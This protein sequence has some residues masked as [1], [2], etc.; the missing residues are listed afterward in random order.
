MFGKHEYILC[1]CNKSNPQ[2]IYASRL[3]KNES[4]KCQQCNT[5]WSDIADSMHKGIRRR[6]RGRNPK[7]QPW[8]S[9]GRGWEWRRSGSNSRSLSQGRRDQSHDKGAKSASFKSDEN[10]FFLGELQKYLDQ[11]MGQEEAIQKS[12]EAQEKRQAEQLQQSEQALDDDQV[13][14]LWGRL[15]HYKS[16]CENKS[17]RVGRL[18]DQLQR[19]K[20]QQKKAAN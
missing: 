19:A 5:N 6:S 13:H 14:A 4:L 2:W 8:S 12:R 15:K 16:L 9:A 18:T 7:K 10:S 20:E 3:G 11:G 1:A 17:A